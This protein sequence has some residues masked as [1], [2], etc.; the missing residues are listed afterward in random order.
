M[1]IT[2]RSALATLAALPLAARAQAQ[3]Q[4]K[5]TVPMYGLIGK[6]RAQPGQRDAIIGGALAGAL[7][8]R[9]TPALIAAVA[10]TQIIALALLIT[11]LRRQQRG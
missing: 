5:E 8:E 1:T 11:T 6:M 3:P 10:T 9:S 4:N 7:Y 2:R